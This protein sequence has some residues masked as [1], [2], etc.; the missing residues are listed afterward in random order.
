MLW[1]L[2]NELDRLDALAKGYG[3]KLILTDDETDYAKTGHH[4]EGN[5]IDGVER[6]IK[7]AARKGRN[8]VWVHFMD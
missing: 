2:G 5:K 7:L 1:E 4:Y 6:A 8:T 3:I